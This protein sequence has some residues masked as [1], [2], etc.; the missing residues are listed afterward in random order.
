MK[1]YW[2]PAAYSTLLLICVVAVVQAAT[3][4]F[5]NTANPGSGLLGYHVYGTETNMRGYS[6]DGD[7]SNDPKWS[8][9][10]ERTNN[11][12]VLYSHAGAANEMIIRGD[13]GQVSFGPSVTHPTGTLQVGVSGGTATTPRIGIGVGVWGNQEGL[14]IYQNQTGT[15]RAK[16]NFNNTF[17]MGSDS[18]NTGTQDY[19]MY[20]NATGRF[21]IRAS[22][23]NN[24]DI[25]YMDY[26]STVGGTL[27]S[28]GTFQHTGSTLGF[29]N[30]TPMAKPTITGCQCDGTALASLITALK[31][32]GLVNDQTTP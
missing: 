30:A 29:Y 27:K 13:T 19:W 16:I 15:K 18:T 20:N 25:V 8:L 3:G 31:N 9:G 7:T 26:G 5:S 6:L 2:Q 10:L 23:A 4:V 12:F 22:D 21:P 14:Y 32:M 17:Q 11:D 24:T 28:T 1:R